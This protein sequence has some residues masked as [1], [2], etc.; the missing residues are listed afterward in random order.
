MGGSRGREEETGREGRRDGER[1][2]EGGGEK[3]AKQASFPPL[4]LPHILLFHCNLIPHS[5]FTAFLCP[6]QITRRVHHRQAAAGSADVACIIERD[7]KEEH[8]AEGQT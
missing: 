2:E 5:T 3:A 1:K 8:L 4:P 6:G 7:V